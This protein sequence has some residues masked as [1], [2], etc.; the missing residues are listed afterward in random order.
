MA[1]VLAL[2]LLLIIN[3]LII[4]IINFNGV[5]KV[6]TVLKSIVKLVGKVSGSYRTSLVAC[7]CNLAHRK[8]LKVWRLI[9]STSWFSCF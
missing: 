6:S 1:A 3:L 4:T 5:L 7:F 9:V 2:L 8:M